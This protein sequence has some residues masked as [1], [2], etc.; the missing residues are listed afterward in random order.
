MR[1]VITSLGEPTTELCYWALTRL[2][3]RVYVVKSSTSLWGKLNTIFN[4]EEI[5]EEDF[6]RVDSDVIVNKNVLEL[7]QQKDLWWYQGLT[8]DWFKQD[9]SHGGVQFYR[10]ECFPAIKKH[11]AE[12]ENEERPETYLSRL[13]E[14]MEPRQFGTFE[15]ICGLHG[16]KQ[17]DVERIKATKARRGQYDNY[18]FE[19][20]ERISAL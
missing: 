1:A 10:K 6:L 8:F 14:F 12:A 19:L 9:S 4:I 13:P 7:V 11:I 20:A 3:F 17:D 2:G 16:Y 5:L 18:D 15:K